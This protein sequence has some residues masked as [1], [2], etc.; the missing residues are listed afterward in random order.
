MGTKQGIVKA[1][2]QIIPTLDQASLAL[3]L[4]QLQDEMACVP[5]W[6]ARAEAWVVDSPD[7]YALA[8]TF[9]GGVRYQR[10]I[11]RLK[12]E[13][14]QQVVDRARDFLKTKRKEAEDQFD[15]I[16]AILTEKMDAQATRERIAAEAEERRLNEEKRIREEKEAAE[17][18]RAQEN[19][20]EIER[21][22]REREIA[23]ARKAGEL[24]AAEAKKLQKEAEEK[25]VRDKEA[26]QREEAAAKENFK[27]VEVKPNLPTIT[28]SRRHRNFFAD[29]VDFD[30]LLHKWSYA[31]H[32]GDQTRANFLRQFIMEN[33]Q[34]LGKAARETQ[35]S[36]KLIEMI[37]GIRAWDK[38]RT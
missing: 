11:P 27:P 37:P 21:K 2:V 22:Q 14:F 30:S 4:S 10:K 25:A 35:D 17:R 6:K 23:E 36:K 3:A 28:G 34:T 5:E 8:G 16:D 32:A 24:K 33:Q 20:A 7:A 31:V 26:A 15:A 29:Y 38:D 18:R 13:A 9:R 12:L 19:Q 1:E